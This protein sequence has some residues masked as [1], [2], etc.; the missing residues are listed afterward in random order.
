[1]WQEIGEKSGLN[2]SFESLEQLEMDLATARMKLENGPQT[3]ESIA[4]FQWIV[5]NL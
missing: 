3:V 5:S 2:L 1:M 4:G